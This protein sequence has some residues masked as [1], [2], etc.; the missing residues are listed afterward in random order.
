MFKLNWFKRSLYSHKWFDL[1]LEKV[2]LDY[3]DKKARE[4][5]ETE[6]VPIYSVLYDDV[7]KDEPVEDDKAIGLF[8]YHKDKSTYTE[9]YRLR[10]IV[11][12]LGVDI[13]VYP[14]Y[15]PVPRIEITERA[16]NAFT[17]IHE[18]GHYFLYKRDQP[19]TELDANLYVEEFFDTYLPPFFKWIYQIEINV[20][21][22]RKLI[23]TDIENYTLWN[24]YNEYIKNNNV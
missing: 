8:I 16:E 6:L 14:E 1:Y 12:K 7:N 18:L 3:I 13:T 24:D 23:F 21:I 19:Q 5:A 4:L 15:K 22:K 17:L 2:F 20:R 9:Y 11:Q 10:D